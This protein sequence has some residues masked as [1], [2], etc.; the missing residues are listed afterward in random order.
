MATRIQSETATGYD[1]APSAT[2]VNPFALFTCAE[3]K[4]IDN[5]KSI[6]ERKLLRDS[7]V[8]DSPGLVVEYLTMHLAHEP[9]EVFGVLLLDNKHRVIKTVDLFRGTVDG[10]AVYPRVVLTAALEHHASAC[11]FYHNHPSGNPEPSQSDVSLTAR[12][13][14]VLALVEIRVLDHFVI[15]GTSSVSLSERGDI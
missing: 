5:A 12:L 4:I 14:D 13:K 3:R 8:L 2:P 1:I 9:F 15:G 6:I 10:A 7:S 11:I